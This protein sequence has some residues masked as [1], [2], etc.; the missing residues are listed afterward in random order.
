MLIKRHKSPEAVGRK[1]AGRGLQ[2]L[3]LGRW[4]KMVAR[5]FWRAQQPQ[6]QPR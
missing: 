6:P 3:V 5:S 4:G 1:V 2:F